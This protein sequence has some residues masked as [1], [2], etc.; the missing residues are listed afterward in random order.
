QNRSKRACSSA[1]LCG[2]MRPVPQ[3]ARSHTRFAMTLKGKT[4]VVT[5]STSGI[6]HGIALALA[7]AGA[8]IVVNGL[9]TEKDNEK[10]IAQIKAVGTR[11]AFD[12]ANMLRHN[13]IA[14]MI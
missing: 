9:G 1:R 3:T 12:P 14:E 5:G 7:K 13:Q 10:A 4:A 11:V 6:G 8:N 2:R